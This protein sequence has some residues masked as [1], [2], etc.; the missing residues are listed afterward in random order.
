M[1]TL[2]NRLIAISVLALGC[3]FQRAQVE[4]TTSIVDPLTSLY[5]ALAGLD[6]SDAQ[7]KQIE[8]LW[9][10]EEPRIG[11][12]QRAQR[13]ASL[14]EAE[15]DQPFDPARV[16]TLLHR[17]AEISAYLRG[18]E[19]RLAAAIVALLEPSQRSA[20]VRLRSSSASGETLGR[21]VGAANARSI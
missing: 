19:S 14:R 21:A 10:C 18:T 3:T 7:R 20:F 15:V 4:R 13:I 17:Q 1:K 16:G 11:K 9:R 5:Q 2:R 8:V 6:L 12:L